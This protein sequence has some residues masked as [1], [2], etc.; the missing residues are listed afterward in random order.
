MNIGTS[1]DVQVGSYSDSGGTGNVSGAVVFSPSL[2]QVVSVS[3]SGS[4]YGS[5]TVSTGSGAINFSGSDS[6]DKILAHIF[7]VTFKT[8]AAGTAAVSFNSNSQ[9]ND[10]ATT[11]KGG[12]FTIIDPNPPN[13]SKPSTPPKPV[14]STPVTTPSTPS[15][16]ST[17]APTPDPTGLIDAVNI[18][19]N[20][21]SAAI[22]WRV[23]A[24]NPSASLKY[25][26]SFSQLDKQAIITRASDGTFTTTITGLTPGTTS[27]FTI[28][29][30]GAGGASGNY[31]DRIAAKG[32][33]VVLSITENGQ[34]AQ[35]ATVKIGSQTYTANNGQLAVSLAAG[36]YSGTISTDTATLAINLT[37]AD[38]SIPADGS[39][40]E[41]QTFSYDLKSSPLTAGSNSQFSIITFVG[42]LVGGG[43]VLTI[44]FLVFMNYRRHK[45]DTEEIY[46][47]HASTSTVIV[48]DGYQWS[49]D[50]PEQ[51][52]QQITP[53][54]ADPSGA[55]TPPHANSVYITEEEPLDMFEQ[56]KVSLSTPSDHVQHSPDETPQ[57]PN[58]LHSTTP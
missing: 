36:N 37:V 34:P 4:D 24:S 55:T 8:I 39:D 10:S 26:D 12:A 1:F 49:H 35:S 43:V 48:E 58:S 45:Y 46:S 7:T 42:A 9:V 38:K 29:A 16:D 47:T 21:S 32:Y 51:P 30:G 28:I 14:V 11:F 18:D 3:T 44:A 40:P 53:T 17:P 13:T 54:P 52:L 25:G 57:N 6:S 15:D 27:Y 19:P 50:A 5:P 31:S 41:S 2:L 22:S 20:Y 33:T 23:N 56:A